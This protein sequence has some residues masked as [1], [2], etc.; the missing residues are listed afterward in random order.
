MSPAQAAEVRKLLA[1]LESIMKQLPA[2]I[3]RELAVRAK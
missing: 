1:E 2:A 3:E